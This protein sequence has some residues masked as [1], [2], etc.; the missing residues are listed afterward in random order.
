MTYTVASDIP[1]RLRVRFGRY[2]FS[3]AQGCALEETLTKIRGVLSA[4]AGYRTGS[5][6]IVYAA[7]MRADVLRALD[8]L[9]LPAAPAALPE[10]KNRADGVFRKAL[11]QLAGRQC[12]RRLLPVPLRTCLIVWRSLRFLRRGAAVLCAGR[13]NVDV[14]D[15]AAI[16]GAM[17]LRD[18]A[19]A[20][21]IMFLLRLSELLEAH[22]LQ[23]TRGILLESL[24]VNTDVVW[25]EEAGMPRRIS[26]RDLSIGDHVVARAGGV[27]PVDGEVLSGEAVVNESSMTGEA[28]G[29]FK[30]QGDTVFAG[31]SLV[32]GC[33][34]VEARAWEGDTRVSRIVRIIEQA[35]GR[36]ATAQGRAEQ[37]AD[38]LVPFSFLLSG[39]VLL[40]TRNLTKALSVLL[41]DYSCAVKLATPVA[42]LSAMREASE[43]GVLV[44]G[45]RFLE[46]VAEADTF[47]FDKTGTLTI[48]AP[49]VSGVTPFGARTREEV[50]R[51]AACMEE[52]FPHSVA[53][54][55]VNAAKAEELRHEEE[56]A[57]VE[58]IAAHGVSTFI[59]GK[60]AV[61]GSRHFIFE[62][63]GVPLTEAECTAL[64]S[65]CDSAIFLA[66]DGALAGCI[67]VTDPPRPEAAGA[68]AAL[69][70][71]GVKRVLMMTGDGEAAARKAAA[72]LGIDEFRAQV[73][74]ENKADTIDVLRARGDTV[75]MVGDGIND[76]PALARADASISMRD[77]SDLAQD[78]ADCVLTRSDLR[79][80]VELRVLGRTL[81][82]RIHRQYR[83]IAAFNT[84]VLLGG[85]FGLIPPNVCA[86]LHNLFTVVVSASATRPYLPRSRYG[87]G[88]GL[89]M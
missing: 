9:R 46:V 5:L 8:A 48:A 16:G 56:H 23:K 21:S 87:P 38:R 72:L 33:L 86:L 30:K 60:R 57:E 22:T 51:L 83:A 43:L 3:E 7:H 54:A 14:L 34:T 2:A 65:E 67:A 36:K 73:L 28:Q 88:V 76:A 80:L 1:G 70:A 31:T 41:V 11:L 25:I 78:V 71:L 79:Q 47:V 18:F 27:I 29:V 55:I 69:R 4:R 32:E 13:L 77:A 66:V 19:A 85:L 50:L 49:R 12:V 10:G 68:V 89:Q 24:Q 15:A 62:D 84:A 17:V 61:I 26:A 44:K 6:L 74:P 42:V 52:H 20:S 40:A 64:G 81:L 39:L 59:H 37:L 45:G 58:Y 82:V 35:E 53:R 63:E 75:V